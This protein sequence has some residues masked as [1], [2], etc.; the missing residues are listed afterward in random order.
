MIWVH[1][2]P[3]HFRAPILE[4]FV[5]LRDATKPHRFGIKVVTS[6]EKVP[7]ARDL[8]VALG[9]DFLLDV[10]NHPESELHG[11]RGLSRFAAPQ[12]L[13]SMTA[14][15]KL[16]E[17]FAIF[18]W[19]EG[20]AVRDGVRSAAL[21]TP[22]KAKDV[23]IHMAQVAYNIAN[24]AIQQGVKPEQLAQEG[25]NEPH[26]YSD[27]SPE[28]VTDMECA[29]LDTMHGYGLASILFNSGVGWPG[30]FDGTPN[31]K[32]NYTFMKR[33]VDLMRKYDFL[34]GHEYYDPGW[35]KGPQEG[36]GSY[37]GRM[38]YCP[39][40]VPWL[41]TE[42]GADSGVS[43]V[44]GG[45]WRDIKA[46]SIQG[47]AVRFAQHLR[48]MAVRYIEDKRPIGMTPFTTDIGS[49]DWERFNMD[50]ELL[51]NALIAELKANPLPAPGSVIPPVDPPPVDP[52]P[53]III[54]PPSGGTMHFVPT[55]IVGA[56]QESGCFVAGYVT[57][58]AG[59]AVNGQRVVFSGAGPDGEWATQ[60]VVTG[61]HAGYPD[62][63][64]G[65]YSHM[66]KVGGAVKADWWLWIVDKNKKR[67]S[68]I[69]K[70]TTDGPGGKHNS[71]LADWQAHVEDPVVVPPPEEDLQTLIHKEACRLIGSGPIAY[72]PT[73]AFWKYAHAAKLGAPMTNEFNVG[74]NARAQGWA[75]G[76]TFVE[77]IG[78]WDKVL[79]LSW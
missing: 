63:V 60:P 66:L 1:W 2:I 73:H 54:P 41:I 77:H 61:P 62:W 42:C 67:I 49:K 51:W 37:V 8:V 76:I 79:C 17:Y 15:E 7:Y 35:E 5:Q 46:G 19:K 45:G 53:V 12:V 75:M 64:P 20:P 16:Q 48:W 11:Q 52:P 10:R 69:V 21:S 70:L 47:A 18:P 56:P 65:F 34:A 32:P 43:G 23:G 59:L 71:Y 36:F 40:N 4:R 30:T 3:V 31:T 22:Q 55:T 58:A 57:D 28:A 78:E 50:D 38:T 72:T 6:D 44:W 14:S 25:L 39:Y 9:T 27:E 29:R 26:Y 13:D 68:D 74:V 33:A 24:D